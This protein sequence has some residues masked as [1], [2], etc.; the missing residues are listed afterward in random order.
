[1]RSYV[2]LYLN[3]FIIHLVRLSY[4][5]GMTVLF[6]WVLLQHMNRGAP[7]DGRH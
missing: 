7:C 2:S 1:M 4:Y 6:M 3:T 5:G